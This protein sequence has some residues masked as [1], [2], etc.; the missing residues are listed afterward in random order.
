MHT[1]AFFQG[2]AS[3]AAKTLVKEYKRKVA[4]LAAKKGA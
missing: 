4:T 1:V 3:D 2:F